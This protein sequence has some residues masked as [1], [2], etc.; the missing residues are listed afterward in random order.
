[1]KARVPWQKTK[2]EEKAMMDEINRQMLAAHDRFVV[3]FDAAI[4]YTLHARFGFGKKRLREF[5]EAF[6]EVNRQLVEHYEMPG[7]TLWLCNQKLLEIGV[8]V[9]QWSEEMERKEHEKKDS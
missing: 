6:F 1:M 2:A 5:F 3:D 8:D 7:D 4:L 9:K